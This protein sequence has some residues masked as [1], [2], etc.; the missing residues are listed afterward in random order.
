MGNFNNPICYPEKIF[1]LHNNIYL[2]FLILLRFYAFST[3][4]FINYNH[5]EE[6]IKRWHEEADKGRR[7]ALRREH[8]I[9]YFVI[10]FLSFISLLIVGFVGFIGMFI[11]KALN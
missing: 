11:T 5:E 6:K 7:E 10:A 3:L 2:V 9:T 8:K 1:F 4:F